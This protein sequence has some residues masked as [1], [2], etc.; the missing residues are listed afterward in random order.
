MAEHDAD[1]GVNEKRPAQ[2]SEEVRRALEQGDS[3]YSKGRYRAAIQTWSSVLDNSGETGEL[4]AADQKALHTRIAKA[5]FARG[6]LS[7]GERA[8]KKVLRRGLSRLEEAVRWE[9]HN[10]LY[11]FE[12]A[13]C[14]WR[15]DERERAL[16]LFEM[17]LLCPGAT[18]NMRYYTALAQLLG[19]KAQKALATLSKRPLEDDWPK[20]KR[21]WVRLEACATAASSDPNMALA[22]LVEHAKSDLSEE[23][24]DDIVKLASTATPNTDL[25]ALLA[26]LAQRVDDAS[27][28]NKAKLAR[29]L[30]DMHASL[31]DDDDAIAWWRQA[32][33]M[34]QEQEE[35][36]KICAMCERRALSALKNQELETAFH[37]CRLGLDAAPD[38]PNLRRLH[39]LLQLQSAEILWDKGEQDEAVSRWR[40]LMTNDDSLEASWNVAIAAEQS[41]DPDQASEAWARVL[42]IAESSKQPSV[43]RLAAIR[44]ACLHVQRDDTDQARALLNRSA[45]SDGE[46]SFAPRLLTLLSLVSDPVK[47]AA[48]TLERA[49]AAAPE[50]AEVLVSLAAVYDESDASLEAKIVRWRAAL[51]E[52]DE[53]W[54]RDA[55]RKRT[56]DLGLHHWQSGDLDKAMD[57]FAS[58]LLDN[59]SEPDG[60]IWCGTIHL[61]RGDA[62][63]ASV[64]FKQALAFAPDTSDPL[65]KIGGCY[66]MSNTEQ[67]AEEYFRKAQSTEPS[68]STD[69][70][71]AEVCV[72][73]GRKDVAFRY[74]AEAVDHSTSHSPE[75]YRIAQALTDIRADNDLTP[76]LEKLSKVIDRPY[77][78]EFLLAMVRILSSDLQSAPDALDRVRQAAVEQGD[79][80]VVDDVHYAERALILLLTNGNI[81]QKE[82][83]ERMRAATR[84]WVGEEQSG[85]DEAPIE[86]IRRRALGRLQE[87][88]K[89]VLSKRPNLW[90]MDREQPEPRIQLNL[91][92]FSQPLQ[93]GALVPK[94][95]G[96]ISM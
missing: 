16:L 95:I 67:E 51:D 72:E 96:R 53:D 9:P 34:Q 41:D 18:A 25:C 5:Y 83:A 30:G 92:T 85:E 12:T 42:T 8:S 89:D 23:W 36:V 27:N 48:T 26:D 82:I 22:H 62:Q 39:H 38:E 43:V 17:A 68:I 55:W 31:G 78:M 69:L 28:A 94:S 91:P 50:D 74:L 80:A 33:T 13:R 45:P 29:L 3:Q 65:V 47:D 56:L 57:V 49:R 79:T 44:A 75:L 88:V 77:R 52:S 2:P 15:L 58:L 7:L 21:P 81:D 11:T 32:Y 61:Q 35:S 1:S 54:V 70:R 14:H 6:Q 46:D 40:S 24:V 19:G 86:R 4:S 93:V 20:L 63:R 71:I 64:C 10:A 84:R 87:T 60:W 59:R 37:W 73:I 90:R 76:L 66:L